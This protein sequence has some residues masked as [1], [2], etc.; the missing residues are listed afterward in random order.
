M[1]PG[2]D[3]RPRIEKPNDALRIELGR[4][5]ER[6]LPVIPVLVDG[7]ELPDPNDLPEDVSDLVFR[8]SVELAHHRWDRD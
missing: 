7:A 2:S 5:L 8:G 1:E 4:A 6:D 3:G